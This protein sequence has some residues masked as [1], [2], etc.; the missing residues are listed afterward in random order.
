MGA[1]AL[2]GGVFQTA[3]KVGP[4]LV[5]TQA[6][7]LIKKY[8]IKCHTDKADPSG[9]VWLGGITDSKSLTP[10]R[11][12]I[13][14]VIKAVSSKHMPPANQ[15]QPTPQ[16][17]LL[18]AETLQNGL[19]G[20]CTVPDPGK[21][22][23]RR[24]N[25]AEYNNTI[26]DLFGLDFHPADDFPSDDVGSGFDNI[27]E[28]LS[29]SPLHLEKYLD[30]AEK[31]AFRAIVVSDKK[32]VRFDVDKF[33]IPEGCI[34]NGELGILFLTGVKASTQHTFPR[35][36][37]YRLK[38]LAGGMQAGDEVCKA[39]VIVGDKVIGEVNVAADATK[40]IV[41]EL[42]LDA[43]AGDQKIEVAFV[44]DF[45]NPNAPDPKRRDRNLALQYVEV[46]GPLDA[47]TILPPSHRQII[48]ARPNGNNFDAVYTQ[49]FEAFAR[50]AFRRTPTSA[51][52]QG[53]VKIAQLAPANGE[54]F[55]RGVQL[56]IT[57]C[58]VSPSFLFRVEAGGSRNLNDF[59]IASR[60]SYFLWSS[61]PDETLLALAEKGALHKPEILLEEALRLLSDAK[62][63]ALADNFAAQWLQLRKLETLSISKKAFPTF[64]AKLRSSMI[65][66]TKRFF[67]NMIQE[68]RPII[69]FLDSDYTF[70]NQPLA[71]LYGMAG[72]VGDEF[73]RVTLQDRN[74]G[75]ILG[76]ASFLTVTSNP[77]RTS[78]VKRGKFILD[79]IL[80]TPPP[81]APP[82]IPALTE[83]AKV[84]K[85]QTMRQR[86]EQH[87]KDPNCSSC[88][89]KMDPLG[90]SLENFN[91]MGNW[92]TQDDTG[93]EV[94]TRGDLPDGAKVNGPDSLK[95]YL[96]AHQDEFVR[97][98][99]DRL[100][101]YALGRELTG[102]DRCHIDNV[103]KLTKAKEFRFRSFITAV[104]QSDAFLKTGQATTSL[105]QG[106]QT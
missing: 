88:H 22:T 75:G 106:T 30:A 11:R 13:D 26:R 25:R 96:M 87:R 12:M 64:T 5:S 78:P 99:T 79:N 29:L 20:D 38:F 80:G 19:N 63:I 24:L 56:G 15:P 10:Q 16:E 53:L 85:G 67:M 90:L 3:P 35:A 48:F 14:Q 57:A 84:I 105:K 86:M 49:I 51:E 47:P 100:F 32:V 70:V 83:D 46:V 61:T 40:P 34:I 43:A 101:T 69:D 59:E 82:A 2:L 52:I 65:Q 36:G 23:L 92:R 44:N 74:R 81:P 97:C 68:D 60:L 50:R 17:R 102:A 58:L 8:C 33:K 55:E 95:K 93:V 98:F 45:Y 21:V 103:V 76:Q 31:I 72:I 39:R 54:S 9:G 37:R 6:K 28:V 91:A 18:L 1:I 104:I 94:D 7:P 73:R 66:E 4:D 41:Y 62:S 71:E 42:P 77:T 27:G 89:T